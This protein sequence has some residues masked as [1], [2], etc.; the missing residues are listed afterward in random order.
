MCK[1]RSE[2]ETLQLWRYWLILSY[3]AG[4]FQSLTYINLDKCGD[5][6]AA[7]ATFVANV[8]I[9]LDYAGLDQIVI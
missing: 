2:I 9:T 3:P 5:K 1:K 4:F 6:E 7:V 8:F